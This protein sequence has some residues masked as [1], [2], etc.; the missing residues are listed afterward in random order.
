MKLEKVTQD[1]I[2]MDIFSMKKKGIKEIS[3]A[4]NEVLD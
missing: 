4:D 1:T 2:H 3:I